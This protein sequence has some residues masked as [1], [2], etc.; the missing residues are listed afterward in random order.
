MDKRFLIIG[1]ILLSLAIVAGMVI[2]YLNRARF[3]TMSKPATL[4]TEQTMTGIVTNQ[5]FSSLYFSEWSEPLFVY[6]LTFKVTPKALE[7]NYPKV[8]GTKKTVFASHRGQLLLNS[9]AGDYTSKRVLDADLASVGV[10]M[11]A[12]ES[13]YTTRFVRGVPAI[14][15]TATTDVSLQLTGS[16]LSI[17]NFDADSLR[18]Q[19][20][21]GVY[22]VVPLTPL[23][24]PLIKEENVVVLNLKQGER[25]NLALQPDTTE[26][27]ASYWRFM[28]NGTHFSYNVD[29]KKVSTTLEY[30]GQG[31]PLISILPHALTENNDTLLGSYQG[32]R[33][34]MSLFSQKDI[35]STFA[36]NEFFSTE[37]M[38][39]TLSKNQV[40]TLRLKVDAD[41]TELLKQD[42][43]GGVYFAGKDLF[44]RAQLY[45]LALAVE[46]SQTKVL[47]DQLVSLLQ[48]RMTYSD[49][50][51]AAY[52]Y[53]SD[54]PK[55]ILSSQPEFGHEF[56]ND[57]HFHYSYYLGTLGIL[58]EHRPDLKDAFLPTAML[59]VDDIANTDVKNGFPWVRGFDVYEGHSWADG[60]AL[61][62]DGNNQE[63][64]SEAI[65]RWYS[66][67]RFAEATQNEKLASLG[68]MGMTLEQES[69]ATYWLGQRPEKYTFPQGYE[70]PIASIVWGG[71]VD[72]ATW[73]SPNPSHVFGIQFLPIFPGLS[74]LQ[75]PSVWKTY[76]P[77]YTLRNEA[78]A[79]NDIWS[80]MA[81]L[82]GQKV[83]DEL[84]QYEQ[85]MTSAWYYLWNHFWLSQ[86]K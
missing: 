81:A 77:F 74:Y 78:D 25:V 5:W 18:L 73:F 46:S 47:E 84:S 69:A 65:N 31:M 55:G 62:G 29:A 52:F 20:D 26:L 59:L 33:G 51:S 7:I 4:L 10:E 57:H 44:K 9:T 2:L 58:L 22:V 71:K 85:G 60:R 79:W 30:L 54:S 28:V 50:K 64:T 86:N 75:N 39:K 48:E 35:V 11:C 76:L 68:V 13:C 32:L 1:S 80:S 24:T 83:P 41:I 72:F 6:P 63:S 17:Q 23:S 82:N 45:E 3:I 56:F 53:S 21:Q 37:Q 34:T 38:L 43:T 36:I 61:A 27:S 19:S 42:I 8:V 16:I 12:G 40:A 14:T 70:Y 66:L 15:I 49:S 67:I